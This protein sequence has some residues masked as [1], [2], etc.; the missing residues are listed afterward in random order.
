MNNPV[1][2]TNQ[3]PTGTFPTGY[4]PTFTEPNPQRVQ[5]ILITANT[6]TGTLNVTDDGNG[7]LIGDCTA[8]TIDYLTGDIAGLLFSSAVPDGN[9]IE[10]AYNPS[11][12]NR[13]QAVLFYQNQI[14]LRPVPDKGYTVEI[15]AYRRPSQALFG[16]TNPDAPTLTGRPELLEWW[17]TIAAG[18]SKKIF[19]DRQD[20]DGVMMM[21]KMLQERYS[22]NEKRTYAQ[23]GSQSMATIYNT[24][25]LGTYQSWGSSNG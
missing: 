15:T 18:A 4:P 16:S 20:M 17:E 25:S 22:L 12:P 19:E 24:R 1:Q 23:L 8:G 21:D 11:N 2:T 14:T 9:A 7:N 3:Q 13:P 10:I 6:S 5:N